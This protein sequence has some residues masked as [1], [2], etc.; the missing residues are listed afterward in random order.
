MTRRIIGSM[1]MTDRAG[2]KNKMVRETICG[3]EKIK[4]SFETKEN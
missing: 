3:P 1:C 4:F 2:K